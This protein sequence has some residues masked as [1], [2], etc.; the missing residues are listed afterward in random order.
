MQTE[1]FLD[2]NWEI[3]A[4]NR[5]LSPHDNK[6]QSEL[7]RKCIEVWKGVEQNELSFLVIGPGAQNNREWAKNFG[8]LENQTT[9]GAILGAKPWFLLLNDLFIFAGICSKKEFIIPYDSF[10]SIP[11]ARLWIREKNCPTTFG[12]EIL[13]IALSDYTCHCRQ[14][15]N[16]CFSPTKQHTICSL[17]QKQK[18]IAATT[19]EEFLKVLRNIWA[20]PQYFI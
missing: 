5:L 17:S 8:V 18:M 9:Q 16:I 3:F 14:S 15:M 10:E 12:R 4:K 11:E 19:R 20:L 13:L 7:R 6:D 1:I 2:K